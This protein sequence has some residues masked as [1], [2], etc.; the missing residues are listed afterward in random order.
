VNTVGP[1]NNNEHNNHTAIDVH[2]KALQRSMS[3][4]TTR[5]HSPGDEDESNLSSPSTSTMENVTRLFARQ[6]FHD[7]PISRM[8]EVSIEERTTAFQDLHGALEYVTETPELVEQRLAELEQ[9]LLRLP[10][11]KTQF[12]RQATQ[13]NLA[14][15]ESLKLCFLR[16]EHFDAERAAIR[17]AG[18]FETK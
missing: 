13:Q 17:M 7:V 12:L 10:E 9:A 8:Y 16:A 14:Y 6:N 18:H 2:A 11:E 1:Q 3:T 5:S 15:V 4:A